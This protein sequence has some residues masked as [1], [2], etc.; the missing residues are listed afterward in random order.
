MI[1]MAF[2]NILYSRFLYN[3]L[4]AHENVFSAAVC[5]MAAACISESVFNSYV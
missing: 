4:Y 2:Y 3:D 5:L 1:N